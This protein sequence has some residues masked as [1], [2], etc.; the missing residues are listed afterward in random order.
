[1]AGRLDSGNGQREMAINGRLKPYF[2][3]PPK[4]LKMGKV[5]KAN[6]IIVK[7]DAFLH[8]MPA[9]A[10]IYGCSR[11]KNRFPGCDGMSRLLFVLLSEMV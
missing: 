7:P 6:Q 8:F 4:P 9:L 11:R 2:F 5:I 10:E 1:V 3:N